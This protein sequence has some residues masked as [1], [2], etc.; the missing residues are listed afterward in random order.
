MNGTLKIRI[1]DAFIKQNFPNFDE[2]TSYKEKKKAIVCFP[3]I[4]AVESLDYDYFRALN[5]GEKLFRLLSVMNYKPIPVLPVIDNDTEKNFDE[6]DYTFMFKN[7]FFKIN[8]E[9][10]LTSQLL[11]YYYEKFSTMKK[12]T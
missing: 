3:A 6:D 12:V 10:S 11:A 9:I 5:T 1:D 8:P 4:N 2:F 7:D